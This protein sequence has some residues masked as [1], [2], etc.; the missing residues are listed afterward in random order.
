MKWSKT[1]RF[2][3]PLRR[4][5]SDVPGADVRSPSEPD[6]ASLQRE[7]Q[8]YERGVLDGERRLSDQLLQQRSEIQRLHAGVLRSLQEAVGGVLQDSE[9]LLLD[10]AFEV[11]QKTVGAIPVSRELVEANVR[12]ALA[13]AKDATQFTIQLH[14]ED[15]EILK[16]QTSGLL[17]EIEPASGRPM[18]FI[19]D[20]EVGRGGCV[21]RTE[22]GAIDAR[23]ET[24]LERLRLAM[25]P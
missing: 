13:E 19:D 21:V 3:S 1:I 24:R 5:F 11:A 18:R 15:L 9:N 12:A 25:Q 16:R 14:P 23:R 22:F 10:L 8:A 17:T 4:V 6:E 20:P 7:A 2:Q